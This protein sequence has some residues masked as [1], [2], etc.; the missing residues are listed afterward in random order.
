MSSHVL[1]LKECEQSFNIKHHRQINL[2][3]KPTVSATN[4]QL[5]ANA[6][7]SA[8]AGPMGVVLR[9]LP[10]LCHHPVDLQSFVQR[11]YS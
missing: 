9:L 2:M 5:A 4:R 6:A 1:Y 10:T 11:L 3:I 8:N 7:P